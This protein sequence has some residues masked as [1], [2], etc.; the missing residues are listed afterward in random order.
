M[1]LRRIAC[2]RSA[3]KRRPVKIFHDW[4]FDRLLK[5]D[6]AR[7]RRAYTLAEGAHREQV[8]PAQHPVADDLAAF[9]SLAGD[10]QD[11]ARFEFRD[12]PLDR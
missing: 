5:A 7:I 1:W 3:L 10:Q 6:T 4:L 11:I 2:R 9:M 8:R 12:R